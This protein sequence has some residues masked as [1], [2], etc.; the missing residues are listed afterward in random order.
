MV[1]KLYNMQGVQTTGVSRHDDDGSISYIPNDEGNR[2]WKAYQD[3]L[4]EGN[5]PEA[6][7]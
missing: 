5:T 2:D 7:E 3:W 1:Y 4:A 6:A